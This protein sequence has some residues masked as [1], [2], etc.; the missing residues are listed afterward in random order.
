MLKAT[1]ARLRSPS[2]HAE[3]SIRR[4]FVEAFSHDRDVIPSS[5]IVGRSSNSRDASPRRFVQSTELS[6]RHASSA[7]GSN[8]TRGCGS[9]RSR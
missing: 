6:P 9:S 4:H 7:T 2:R 8:D 1:L 5:C 3:K